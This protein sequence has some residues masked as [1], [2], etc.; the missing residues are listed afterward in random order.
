M[1]ATALY[2]VACMTGVVGEP[3]VLWF[4]AHEIA[5]G[6]VEIAGAGIYAVWVWALDAETATAVIN[7]KSMERPKIAEPK[8]KYVWSHLGKIELPS[9]KVDVRIGATV[10]GLVLS[11][12]DGF[13]PNAAQRHMR[14]FDQ[15]ERVHDRR[16]ETVKHTDTVFTMPEFASKEEWET[17]AAKLRKR[18][19]LSS[20]LYP[21]PERTPL[22]A[23]ISG[24]IEHEDYTVEKVRFEARPGFLVTGNLYRPVGKGP[25]PG[26]ANPHG[27]WQNGRMANEENGS[28]PGRCITLARMGMV[29]FSYDMIG[30]NDSLQ[31]KH[32]W[33]G[34][35]EKLWGLS[36]YAM[37]LW[38]SMRVVDF[39][40]SL[41]DVDPDRIGCT[42]ESGGGTQTFSLMSVDPRVKVAAPVN[43]ISHS[44]QGG[45]LCENAPILRL[46]NSNM[47]IGA[48]MA[49]RPLLMISATGDWTRET[50]RVEFPAIRSIYRLYGAEDRVENVHIKAP[51]NYNKASREAM[52]PFFAKWL[53][54][55]RKDWSK[56]GKPFTEPAFKKEADEDLLVFP[57]KKLPDGLPSAEQ[58]IAEVIGST[59]AKWQA[60]L[61]KKKADFAAFSEHYGD[62]L[63]L[64]LGTSIPAPNDFE[65]ERTGFHENDG[66]VMEQWIL[67]RR[68]VG[69]AVP[70][71]LY[72][73]ATAE[74]QDAVLIVHGGGKAALADKRKG[75]PGPLVAGLIAKGKAVLVIDVFLLGEHHSPQ[76]RTERR[77]EGNFM[78]TFQP[79]DT[80]YRIQDVVTALAYL[81]SRRDMTGN[82][83]LIGLDKGGMW[84]LFA[85][86]LDGKVVNTFIDANHFDP[87]SDQAWVDEYYTPCIRSVGDVDTAAAL[88]AP[89]PVILF[90]APASF[91]DGFEAMYRAAEADTLTAAPDDAP[92]KSLLEGRR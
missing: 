65:P 32:R 6:G 91:S 58:I 19:L 59:R 79:T 73:S 1:M 67:R 34:Q 10:A 78:D 24:R 87:D 90:N 39:L 74:P 43:M 16:A 81:R 26:V 64:V 20:A 29:A 68:C 17:Y 56:F 69:D 47:E 27:H 55:D 21:L 44:M 71:I 31:F 7:G 85:A 11:T 14:V 41:P 45:C 37:Q 61:P 92:V 84:C 77:V 13:D 88:L 62:V 48:L 50:P 2:A 22:N 5:P 38:T 4:D 49:P 9:G 35:R 25:F 3:I 23:E 8:K 53:L 83:D 18:I 66:Y 36:P 28:L 52:Y 60:V 80:G 46:G 54:P 57:N 76:A 15:P 86:A 63:G 12:A 42:G 70:A 89:R 40:Q 30:Y 82:V 33:G 75:S 51:H 72:R